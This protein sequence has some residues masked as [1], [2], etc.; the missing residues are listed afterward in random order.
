MGFAVL[1]YRGNFVMMLDYKYA[2]G[3]RVSGYITS[4]SGIIGTISGLLVGKIANLY[5]NDSKL[6][7]HA[8]IVQ[9]LSIVMVTFSPSLVM[10]I[11]AS[12]PLSMANQVARVCSTNLTIHKGAGQDKGVLLGLGGS[13]L[14]FARMLSPTIGGISQE[15]YISGPSLVGSV[16]AA[17]GVVTMIIAPDFRCSYSKKKQS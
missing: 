17:L 4:Y 3:P 1:I 14:A 11:I 10:L 7:L 16:F 6:L 13:I 12:T 2:A 8:G 5:Q 9:L 15:Y